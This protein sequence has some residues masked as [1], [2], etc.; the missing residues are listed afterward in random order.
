M[1]SEVVTSIL[2]QQMGAGHITGAHKSIIDRCTTN[3]Y[4][5]YL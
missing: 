4:R 5:P 1:K 3:V 2:E